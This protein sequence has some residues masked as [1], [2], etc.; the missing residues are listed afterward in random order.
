MR[1]MRPED[2]DDYF[3]R[4][5]RNAG[6]STRSGRAAAVTVYFR[7]LELRHRA[8]IYNLTGLAVECPLDE[9]NR[10]PTSVD[11]QLR[12]PPSAAEMEQLFGGWRD[13]LASSRKFAPVARNY[14]VARLAADVGLRINEIRMLDFDD[15][16]W[17]LGRFGKLHVRYGKG[18]RRRGPKGQPLRRV[19][20]PAERH[21][22][23]VV[24]WPK[25]L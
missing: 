4:V 19:L 24:L 20:L 5:L 17:E 8:E 11:R 12:V 9:M 7:F 14:V 21:V 2:A 13:E 1:E 23:V 10:P 25:H 3:G 16:H 15:A 6:P 22:E 18:S